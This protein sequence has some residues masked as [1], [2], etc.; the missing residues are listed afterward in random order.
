MARSPVLAKP[1]SSWEE[2]A[3]KD[4]SDSKQLRPISTRYGLDFLHSVKR[5]IRCEQ[6]ISKSCEKFADFSLT[7]RKHLRCTIYI[8]KTCL[9][10]LERCR[11][12]RIAMI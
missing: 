2:N 12:E 4:G 7:D 11:N 9:A 8:C 5:D 10:E 3:S 6:F 1:Q